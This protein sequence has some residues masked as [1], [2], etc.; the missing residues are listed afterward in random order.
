MKATSIQTS[1]RHPESRGTTTATQTANK[2]A[3]QV[4]GTQTMPPPS[5][6]KSTSTGGTQ[7]SPPKGNPHRQVYQGQLDCNHDRKGQPANTTSGKGKKNKKSN[8]EAPPCPGPSAGPSVGLRFHFTSRNLGTG[9]NLHNP[10][11]GMW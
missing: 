5:P 7:I 1:P 8:S 4:G 9:R 6:K 11:Y 3:S 10:V 2:K